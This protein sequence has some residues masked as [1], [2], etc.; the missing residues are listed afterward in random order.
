MDD[1]EQASAQETDEQ[2]AG[3]EEEQDSESEEASDAESGSGGGDLRLDSTENPGAQETE[4]PAEEHLEPAEDLEGFEGG[5]CLKG[6]R[7]NRTVL[8]ARQKGTACCFAS[9]AFLHVQRL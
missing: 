7:L 9:R 8:T 3:S 4:W 5:E 6:R 2:E 1:G